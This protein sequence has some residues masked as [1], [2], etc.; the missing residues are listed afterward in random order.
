MGDR[1]MTIEKLNQR[2]KAAKKNLDLINLDII[3]YRQLRE[4][5][6]TKEDNFK[7]YS[8]GIY[9]SDKAIYWRNEINSLVLIRDRKLRIQART[10]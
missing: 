1:I 5:C 4:L 2:I 8:K 3:K 9:A 10:K 7:Y 6:T